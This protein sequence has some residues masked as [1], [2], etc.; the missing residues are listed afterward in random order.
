MKIVFL[1]TV[2]AVFIMGC[3]STDTGSTLKQGPDNNVLNGKIT[4]KAAGMYE[5]CIELKPGQVF[6]FE[7]DASK[8]VDFNIHYHGTDKVHYP[9]ERKGYLMGEG[10]VDPGTHDF[11]TPEQEFYCLMW[12]NINEEPVEV[13][14]ESVVKD[15]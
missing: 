12:E 9:V 15:K 3:A 11:F 8:V 14:F 4:I 2:L 5:E 7:Y 10:T 13:S 1:I 6:D